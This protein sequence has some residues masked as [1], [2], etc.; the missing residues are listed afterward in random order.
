MTIN[1]QVRDA[2]DP[3]E[4]IEERELAVGYAWHEIIEL[5]T[6]P[7]P[8]CR[9]T[10]VAV[11]VISVVAYEHDGRL[12]TL[13]ADAESRNYFC[14]SVVAEVCKWMELDPDSHG[15]DL[16][17]VVRFLKPLAIG[18]SGL[19]FVSDERLPA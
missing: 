3:G 16:M 18:L 6:D 13:T 9:V 1:L 19:H 11:G 12:Y 17:Q 4:I 14:F 2:D 15:E 7:N 5:L 8:S 10:N